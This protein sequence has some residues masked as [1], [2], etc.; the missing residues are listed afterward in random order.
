MHS[1]RLRLGLSATTVLERE[2]ERLRMFLGRN[3]ACVMCF[4]KTFGIY[5]EENKNGS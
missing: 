2:R 5:I 1:F 4:S 3:Q